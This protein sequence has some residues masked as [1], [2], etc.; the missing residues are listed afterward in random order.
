LQSFLPQF[1]E[2]VFAA[3]NNTDAN[4]T[5]ANFFMMLFLLLFILLMLD[6]IYTIHYKFLILSL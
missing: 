1:A 4:N 6:A 3:N 2:A 5:V